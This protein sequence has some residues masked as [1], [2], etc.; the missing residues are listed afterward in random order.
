MAFHGNPTSNR[1]AA[2]SDSLL[3]DHAVFRLVWTNRAEVFA[4]AVVSQ[5]PSD[6]GFPGSGKAQVWADDADQP[7]RTA[8]LRL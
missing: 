7:A 5:Q 6:A 1:A 3:V 8:A 2:W 4:G